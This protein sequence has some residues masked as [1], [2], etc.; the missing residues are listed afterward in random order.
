MTEE[1]ETPEN[2]TPTAGGGRGGGSWT[3][4]VPGVLLPG[5]LVCPGLMRLLING[6]SMETRRHDAQREEEQVCIKEA[7]GPGAGHGP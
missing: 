7:A 3:L 5:T 1:E 6:V 2:T 4:Q